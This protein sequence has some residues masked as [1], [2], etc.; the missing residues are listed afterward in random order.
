MGHTLSEGQQ[1]Q[2]RQSGDDGGKQKHT[3]PAKAIDAQADKDAGESSGRHSEEVDEVEVGGIT[4]Q[5]SGETV[6]DSCSNEAEGQME[7]VK[8]P[9]TT[10]HIC[11]T[12]EIFLGGDVKVHFVNSAGQ[13]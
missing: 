13:V 1:Q 9:D 5:V 12:M 8:A 7:T 4:A 3:T 6:L 11:Y 2:R 10:L